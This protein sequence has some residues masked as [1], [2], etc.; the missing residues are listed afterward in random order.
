MPARIAETQFVP[1]TPGQAEERAPSNP[2]PTALFVLA[3]LI[4]PGLIAYFLSTTNA[5][6]VTLWVAEIALLLL[7]FARPF[8]GLLLFV[9]LLYIRP[10]EMNADLGGMHLTLFVSVVTLVSTWF[11]FFLDKVKV[12]RT[13]QIG[14]MLGFFGTVLFSALL[15]GSSVGLALQNVGKLVILVLLVLNLIRTPERYRAYVSILILFTGYI[16]VYSIILYLSGYAVQQ[17]DTEVAGAVIERSKATG[18]F[19]DP[20]DLAITITAGLA[21]VMTR[22]T[23]VRGLARLP[24]F[25]LLG[26][27]IPAILLTNSRSGML[28]ML[29]VIVAALIT[30][31]RSRFA[32]M[33]MTC[34]VVGGLAVIASGRMTNFNSQENSANQ[35]LE[36][37]ANG[38]DQ[39]RQ[40]PLTGVGYL[41]FP[42]VNGH[43]AAHN[44]FVLCFAELGL[45]GYFCF[46]GLIYYSF[47]RR[48]RGDTSPDLDPTAQRDL[49][50]SRLALAGLLV[51]GFFLT[52]TYIPVT[53][54]FITLP[55]A[56]QIAYTQN[57][58][59]G[60]L[61]PAERRKDWLRIAGICLGSILF[62][63]LIVY[64]L[65]GM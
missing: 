56:C 28:A 61:T 8:W 4:I 18:I 51:G 12:V 20:N 64:R 21:L 44:T 36:F 25:L 11:H 39:L 45:P 16:A 10:E 62:I 5:I 27:G 32:A 29:V 47:R 2:F 54:L 40:H 57:P 49:L 55:V 52:R 3:A 1:N 37:W 48:S 59:F 30:F 34:V 17:G 13:P 46:I 31:T 60:Q 6:K 15:T 41:Q 26:V 9:V 53:Y 24:Y 35:R 19:G 43:R 58:D 7:A 14:M 65:G 22:I 33:V 23:Q 38:L 42:E 50:G 63:K